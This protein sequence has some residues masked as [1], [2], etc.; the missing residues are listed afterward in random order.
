MAELILSAKERQQLKGEAH[1]LN[2]VV[3]LG[4]E[5]LTDA[6]VKEVDRALTAHGLIKVRAPGDD[7]AERE[8]IFADLAE[9][10]SA[11]RVQAIGKILVLFRPL[12]DDAP[13]K[14][15]AKSATAPARS[16]KAPA[17]VPK[18]TAAAGAAQRGKPGRGEIRGSTSRTTAPRR[19]GGR[20]R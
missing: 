7:R 5:G 15:T 6:V 17:R 19:T 1:R 12:P 2:P 8:Q 9:R 20:A 14:T 11:G 18:K 10:L 4:A 16:P 13:V 3:L